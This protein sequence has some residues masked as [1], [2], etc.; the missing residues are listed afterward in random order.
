MPDESCRICGGSL[1]N[2][3]LCPSCRKITQRI[4]NM[5]GFKTKEQ[6]HSNCLYLESFRTKNGMEVGLIAPKSSK[7]EINQ[8]NSEKT[9][10]L[11]NVLLTFVIVSFFTV[12]FATA[13]YFGLFQNQTSETQ[14]M[15]TSI[16]Q[17]P[18]QNNNNLPRGSFENCLAYGSG[19]SMTVTCPTEYGYAYKTILT[20]PEKLA[21]EFSGEVFS[22]RGISVVEYSD[23]SVVLQYHKNLYTTSFFAN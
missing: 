9:H 3:S 11:R 16:T 17:Q 1:V 14:I 8:K 19:Q 20:V 7:R 23:S 5:C 4:C 15:K 12:G 6:V 10:P 13:N 2:C 18:S 21:S 22:I